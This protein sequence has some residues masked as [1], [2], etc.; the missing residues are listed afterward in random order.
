MA[1]ATTTR[2]PERRRAASTGWYVTG[3]RA[4]LTRAV[5]VVVSGA[6]AF[7]APAAAQDFPP[8]PPD[9]SAITQY[10][11]QVPAAGGPKAPG[12]GPPGKPAPLSAAIRANLKSSG[13]A[14]SHVLEQL[15]TSPE[16]GAPNRRKHTQVSVIWPSENRPSASGSL[17]A[18]VTA[19]GEGGGARF[20]IVGLA[21]IGITVAVLG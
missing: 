12:V 19:V 20:A 13:G 7:V 1:A 6:L 17:S 16:L 14:D 21:L 9:D 4:A 11:E 8:P 10:V 5:V 2:R 18:A 3:V 15:A